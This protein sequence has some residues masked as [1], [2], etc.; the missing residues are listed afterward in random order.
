MQ[1][2]N[3]DMD[4]LF[5]KA[6]EQYPLKTDGAD[7]QKVFAGLQE[8]AVPV[9]EEKE[10]RKRRFLWLFLLLPLGLLWAVYYQSDNQPKQ[11]MAAAKEA[12]ANGTSNDAVTNNAANEINKRSEKSDSGLATKSPAKAGNM[13]DITSAFSSAEVKNNEKAFH[14]R[15]ANILSGAKNKVSVNEQ[16]ELLKP[17][18]GSTELRNKR[19]FAY[20]QAEVNNNSNEVINDKK[21]RLAQQPDVLPNR[22]DKQNAQAN[23]SIQ[24]DETVQNKTDSVVLLNS[25][26]DS[27]ASNSSSSSDNKSKL[28]TAKRK[29][30]GFYASILAS[31]DVSTIKLQRINKTGYGFEV[32]VGYRFSKRFSVESGVNRTDKKYYSTGKYFDKTNTGISPQSEII[33]TNGT[34]AMFEIPANVKYDFAQKKKSTWFATAGLSS[35]LMKDEQYTYYA[36]HSGDYYK[37]TKTYSRSG[38]NLFSVASLSVGYQ[39]QLNKHLSLRAEPYIKMPLGGIGIAKMPI[40]STGIAVGFTRSF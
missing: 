2:V 14:Q 29:Q 30:T 6:A 32:L 27:A 19:D 28:V 40:T 33:Y 34:C 24:P 26:A 37:A 12:T 1:D 39:L 35:Y 5:R 21:N 4:D 10:K 9:A 11:Q 17:S 20:T 3:N 38:N 13:D 18:T 31:F 23:R 8:A 25:K 7:W 15:E 36:N 16:S 22:I